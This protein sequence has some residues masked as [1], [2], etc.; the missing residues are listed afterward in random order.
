MITK[1][2]LENFTG[3]R[4]PH[5]FVIHLPADR[6][7]ITARG[8]LKSKLLQVGSLAI[9]DL[10]QVNEHGFEVPVG[11][12]YQQAKQDD[13]KGLSMKAHIDFVNTLRQSWFTDYLN[14]NFNIILNNQLLADLVNL[15]ENS[16]TNICACIPAAKDNVTINESLFFWPLKNALYELSKRYM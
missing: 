4:C 5:T 8:A 10:E 9:N 1:L 2:L 16:Y 14:N 15:G 12:T 6:K 7:E 11:L 3:K 13:I